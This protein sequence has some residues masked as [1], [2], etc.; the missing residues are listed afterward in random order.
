MAIGQALHARALCLTLVV[1]VTIAAGCFGGDDADNKNAE[2]TR[3]TVWSLEFQPD[4]L[5]ATKA[6]IAAFTKKTHIGVDLVAIGDDELPSRMADAR[7][8]HKLPDV[9]Q[10][11]LDSLHTYARE[12]LLDT[13]APQDVLDRLGDDTF[14]QTALSLASRES[15]IAGVPSDG[16]GQLLIYRKDLFDK[17]GLRPPTTLQA[18][19]RAARRLDRGRLAGI[20]LPNAADENFTAEIFE[21]IALAAGCEL[22]DARG[23]V[24]L[25]TPRCR[26]AFQFYVALARNGA[27]GSVSLTT[28]DIARDTY[29][30]GRTAMMFWS[31][32]VLDAMAGLNDDAK[33]TCPQCRRDPAFLARNSGLVG[34]LSSGNG[35]PAQYGSVSSWGSSR[36]PTAPLHGASLSTCSRM[37]TCA[38]WRSHRRA[39]FPCG[40]A[41]RR[42]P[43][44]TT[45][46]GS[47]CRAGWSAKP[48]SAAFTPRRRSPHSPK[49]SAR[50]GV[51]ASCKGR[52]RSPAHCE[53]HSR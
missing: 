11:P 46:P 34:P 41:M 6:N 5:R 22:V 31:P 12:N 21:H 25:E 13:T 19:Q 15:R 9:A 20:T 45:G 48:R 18:I 44:A 47:V 36:A 29:F 30:A 32:F 52:P 33:P 2:T 28:R 23:H 43:S 17:A 8:A 42:I 53:S 49:A 26:A 35:A 4:R 14:E 16:W 24:S 38:G 37:A 50:F 51:G 7:S 3:I 27:R 40:G 1:L 10:L 39:N